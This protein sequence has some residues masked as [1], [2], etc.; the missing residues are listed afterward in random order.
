MQQ[1]AD[2]FW[3]LN[4]GTLYRRLVLDRGWSTEDFTE[5]LTAQARACTGR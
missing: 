5:W 4:D 3:A 1:A 2:A